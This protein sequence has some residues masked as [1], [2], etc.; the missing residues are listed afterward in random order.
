MTNEEI[1]AKKTKV[2]VLFGLAVAFFVADY[3]VP[4]TTPTQVL[5]GGP[6]W[7]PALSSWLSPARSPRA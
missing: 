4:E 5:M 1:A 6:W 7:S 2:I 3:F